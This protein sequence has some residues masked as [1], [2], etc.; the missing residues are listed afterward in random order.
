MSDQFCQRAFKR[1]APALAIFLGSTALAQAPKPATPTKPAPA[2]KN[3]A[4][5][6]AWT[7]PRTPW[8]DPDL[9]GVWNDATSTPLERPGGVSGKGILADEEAADFQQQLAN[10]LSRDRR[11]GS[12]EA[13]VARAYNEHWMDSRRLKITADK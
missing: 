9:Q 1:L 10:E 13:D 12:A 4:A 7:P 6:K 3:A 2:A 8:G 11:D 5:S